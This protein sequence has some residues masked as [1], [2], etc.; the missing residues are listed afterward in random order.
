MRP[1]IRIQPHRLLWF[2]YPS[3]P[4]QSSQRLKSTRLSFFFSSRIKSIPLFVIIIDWFLLFRTVESNANSGES[5]IQV[6]RPLLVELVRLFQKKIKEFFIL[7]FLLFFFKKKDWHHIVRSHWSVG[8]LFRRRCSR[9]CTIIWS[10]LSCFRSQ[11]WSYFRRA[12]QSRSYNWR[13][14][15]WRIANSYVDSLLCCSAFRR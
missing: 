8:H 5:F 9:W 13:F 11:F 7:P 15:C 14:N 1:P 4:Q 12:F 3:K 2:P 6:I 10:C